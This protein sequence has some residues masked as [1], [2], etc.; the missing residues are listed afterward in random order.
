MITRSP[1]SRSVQPATHP[2]PRSSL[3]TKSEVGPSSNFPRNGTSNGT[4]TSSSNNTLRKSLTNA[5]ELPSSTS[6]RPEDAQ[7]DYWLKQMAAALAQ[8]DKARA[9]ATA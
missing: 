7:S 5:T 6:R 8:R 4:H 2:Q 3:T 9:Q 1:P